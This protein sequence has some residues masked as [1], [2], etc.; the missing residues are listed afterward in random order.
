MDGHKRYSCLPGGQPLPP[1][2]DSR[3]N[4]TGSPEPFERRMQLEAEKDVLL[5][6]YECEK[7]TNLGNDKILREQEHLQRQDQQP[8]EDE[9][10]F[11][12]TAP[13]RI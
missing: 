8:R 2:S 11:E 9:V 5:E 4:M 10:Q 1:S 12:A 6:D 7:T 3:V 13:C